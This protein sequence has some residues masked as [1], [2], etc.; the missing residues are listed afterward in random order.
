M[1]V[2]TGF[3]SNSSSSSYVI[4]KSEFP[5]E[6]SF[7]QVIKEIANKEDYLKDNYYWGY[8]GIDFAVENGYLFL[9]THYVYNEIEKIFASV[10][11][12]FKKLKKFYIKG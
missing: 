12:D 8:E 6:E 3:V 9:E 2:R 7:R 10:G 11:L 4:H 5:S 1:K